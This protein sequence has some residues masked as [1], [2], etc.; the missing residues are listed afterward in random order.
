MRRFLYAMLLYGY[1]AANDATWLSFRGCLKCYDRR[2]G[3]YE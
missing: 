1:L 3:K 2:Q